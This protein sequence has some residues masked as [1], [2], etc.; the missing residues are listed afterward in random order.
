MHD[1]RRPGA[2]RVGAIKPQTKHKTTKQQHKR[3]RVIYINIKKNT[4]LQNLQKIKKQEKE[5]GVNYT[6]YT[7]YKTRI[8]KVCFLKFSANPAFRKYFGI[9]VKQIVILNIGFGFRV[10][11][12]IWGL[13]LK[14][15]F[16]FQNRK[17]ST[18]PKKQS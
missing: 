8:P 10:L 15:F 17:C 3:L 5:K 2:R 14:I 4:K 16:E 6:N 12:S 7:Y 18:P 9:F 11:N 13:R 1:P